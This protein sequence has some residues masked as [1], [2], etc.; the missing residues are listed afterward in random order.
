M[1]PL[2]PALRRCQSDAEIYAHRYLI[3]ITVTLASVLE[4]LDTSIVIVAIPHMMGT[5]GATLDE[6][7]WVSTGYVIAN[8]IVMPISGW[9]SNY[10]GRRNYFA[11]SILLFTGSS[12]LCGNATTLEGLVFWRIIQGLG[13]GGLI[14]TAQATLYETFPPRESGTSMAIFGLGIMVGPMLGPTLGGWITDAMSWPWIFYINLPLGIL[15][16]LLALMYVPDSKYGKRAEQVDGIGFLLLAVAIGCLQAMLERGEKLD[17][18]ASR[19]I[20]TYAVASA[21]A[22]IL[23]VRQELAHEHPIVDLRILGDV[24][25]SLALVFTLLLGGALFSTIFVFPVY[26]QTLLGF[27]ALETGL[28]ILPGAI[29]SGVSMALMGKLT[30]ATRVDLRLFVVAGAMVFGYSMWLH[31]QFT[32]QSGVDDFFWPMILRGI[33]LGM[34]FIPL[35]NLALGNLR[36][37]QVAAGSG[38]YNLTRQLGGSIGIAVSATLFQQFQEKNR[39]EILNH[40]SQFSHQATARLE[41]FKAL[42]ISHGTPETLARGKA[43]WLLNGEIAKQ[44]AM[45]SFERL[46]LWFGVAL[47]A[48]LPLLLLMERGKFARGGGK[49]AP[50]H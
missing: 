21:V 2:L 17:W 23:F 19:E 13:G 12:V 8:V 31:S 42:A 26:L 16:L 40:V 29:A 10:I 41:Q 3:A 11:L 49:Q 47:F 18:F 30:A 36:P 5:L 22:M 34:V 32:T 4:L 15:A 25:F 14:S 27:T 33:G 6:I 37:Q 38:L 7:A 45:L 48:A 24:Q 1:K 50:A 35:N 46:F 39:G 9:L 43:L 20:V 28:V 44:A